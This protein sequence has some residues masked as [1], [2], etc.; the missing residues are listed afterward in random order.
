MRRTGGGGLRHESRQEK[1][2]TDAQVIR[3]V[4]RGGQQYR[5]V[6][7]CHAR[8]TGGRA[9]ERAVVDTN[10]VAA[11]A[12]VN[13]V[14]RAAE[15]KSG[16]SKLHLAGFRGRLVGRSSSAQP[17][18]P[19]MKCRRRQYRAR[20]STTSPVRGTPAGRARTGKRRST[21]GEHS[22]PSAPVA[23]PRPQRPTRASPAE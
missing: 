4:G 6:L 12:M 19:R 14:L 3:V 21:T 23:L 7:A 1:H 17:P 5:P 11:V 18:P 15:G 13:G 9:G 8:R 2:A 10:G 20:P 22:A 16:R